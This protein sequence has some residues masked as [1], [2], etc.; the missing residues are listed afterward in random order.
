MQVQG[1]MKTSTH[2]LVG[3]AFD[4]AIN[5]EAG[6]RERQ[7]RNQAD[8]SAVRSALT[9]LM[10]MLLRDPNEPRVHQVVDRFGKV[11][12]NIYDPQVQQS[13]SL[14]H[15]AEVRQWLEQRYYAAIAG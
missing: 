6:N 2:L 1:R 5:R 12:W 13:L 8:K 15:E 3:H 10:Q 9:H 11:H 4:Q 7:S 14:D